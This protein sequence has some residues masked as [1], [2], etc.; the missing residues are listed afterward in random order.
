VTQLL[1]AYREGD[2]EALDRLVSIV[3]EDLRRIAKAHVRR[4]PNAHTL[5][6]MTLVHEAY[7]RLVD[8]T[9]ANWEDRQHFLSVCAR[10]MRQIVISN[11]RH[12]SAEKRGGSDRQQV[13]WHD[14]L[15]AQPDRA[16]ELLELDR[17]LERLAARDER[18]AKIVECRYFGGFTED[19]TAQAVGAS[20]RTVQRDWKR[21]RAWLREELS[22]EDGDGA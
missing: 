6:T 14:D 10:A 17:A 16:V 12:H 8:Q 5:Q 19:E 21:A 4:G 20:L 11:A 22:G 7:L 13:T 1:H 3:Y 15:A 9:R 18:L 2:R